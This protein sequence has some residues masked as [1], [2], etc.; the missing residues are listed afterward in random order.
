MNTITFSR[1]G[2]NMGTFSNK[3]D[4]RKIISDIKRSASAIGR[5]YP[6]LIDEHGNVI[7]GAHRLKV[8]PAW[9]RVTVPGVESEEQRLLA[10]LISNVCRR[11]VSAEEKTQMLCE[12]GQVYLELGVPHSELIKMIVRKTGMSY[13]W[14]MKYASIDLK[15]RPGLGGH[16]IQE[17]QLGNGV[18]RQATADEQLL[19]E[20]PERVANL[21]SYSNTKFAT[22]IV[23]KRFYLKLEDSAARLGVDIDTIVN[24]ALLL[25]M[26]QMKRLID[27]HNISAVTYATN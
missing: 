27:R 23:D 1:V 3:S 20:P 24:N 18:A 26:R 9:F 21:T 14:V 12:L 4:D 22:I 2:E 25:T 15:V 8:D 6:V 13:R 11:N 19:S 16:K 7:D 10:R 17:Q 5:L